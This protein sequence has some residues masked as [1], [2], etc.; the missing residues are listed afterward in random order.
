MPSV[1]LAMPETDHFVR[2]VWTL[3]GMRA[4]GGLDVDFCV[5]PGAEGT[6]SEK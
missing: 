2:S 5:N 3:V 1:K 6:I 4:G